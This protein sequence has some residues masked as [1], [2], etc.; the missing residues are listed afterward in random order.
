M[1]K[2]KSWL[3]FILCLSFRPMHMV[4]KGFF[5]STNGCRQIALENGSVLCSC[6]HL[7]HFAILLS[8]GVE[9][10]EEEVYI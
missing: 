3:I 2:D 1:S 8:P 5:W 10:R 4:E 6:N 9:V 7:T